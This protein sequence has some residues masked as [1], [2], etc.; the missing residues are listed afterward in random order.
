MFTS[1]GSCGPTTLPILPAGSDFW[2]ASK[3]RRRAVSSHRQQASE[4]ERITEH[5]KRIEA[6]EDAEQ[7]WQA[8]IRIVDQL[9]GDGVPPSNREIRDALLERDRRPS[10]TR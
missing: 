8:V 5:A 1:S 2:R 4:L 10:G 7:E 6:G 3:P 9:V